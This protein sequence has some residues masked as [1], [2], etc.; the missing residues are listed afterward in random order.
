MHQGGS[1]R[2]QGILTT[3][4][5]VQV[6]ELSKGGAVSKRDID[7]PMVSEGGEGGDGSRF[8]ASSGGSGGD[9]DTGVFADKGTG[10]PETAGGVPEGLYYCPWGE[11]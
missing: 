9:E 5:L 6:S 10:G 3:V 2:L 7:D 11:Y 8:L 1:T 4:D